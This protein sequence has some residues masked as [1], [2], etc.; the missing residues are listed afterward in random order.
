[1]A[2]QP[3]EPWQ[4]YPQQSPDDT[5]TY[6]QQGA[7]A[8]G[9]QGAQAQGAGQ[10]QAHAA[11]WPPQSYQGQEYP[12]Q[13]QYPGQRSYSAEDQ[14]RQQE[15]WA[16]PAAGAPRTSGKAKG[17]LGALF[18][19]GF[20]SFVTP[21]IIKAL[22][23]LYAVFMVVWA[24]IFLWLAFKYY[25]ATVGILTLVIVDPV[26]LLLTLGAYRVILELF[27]VIHRMHDDLKAIRERADGRG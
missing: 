20:T 10:A 21:K 11:D 24:I 2:G 13:Q 19:F 18:D 3:Q 6:R 15:Q 25:G 7:Q 14:A 4:S 27:M 1:M 9:A 16:P 22:Y 12:G 26:F 17:F 23:A 5:F 8:Q